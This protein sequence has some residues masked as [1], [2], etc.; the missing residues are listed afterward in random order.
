MEDGR[1]WQTEEVACDDNNEECHGQEG[2]SDPVIPPPHEMRPDE[3]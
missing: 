2:C 3:L 1:R